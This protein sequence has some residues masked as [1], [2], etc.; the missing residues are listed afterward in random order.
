MLILEKRNLNSNT[1][2][3]FKKLNGWE[4]ALKNCLIQLVHSSKITGLCLYRL[5]LLNFLNGYM[6]MVL[7]T[8]SMIAV[9]ETMGMEALMALLE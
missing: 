4:E 6:L 9:Q 5:V 2:R 3:E 1:F 7:M 8:I